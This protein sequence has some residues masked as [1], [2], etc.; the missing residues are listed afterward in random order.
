MGADGHFQAVR[1]SDWDET[2][3]DVKPGDCGLTTTEFLGLLI[4]YGY[5][6]TEG[7]GWREYGKQG[8]AVAVRSC[9]ERIT[10]IKENGTD[11]I[12]ER[13]SRFMNFR[14][15]KLADEEARL[16][17]LLADPNLAYSQRCNEAANWFEGHAQD[18]CVWT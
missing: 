18:I 13:K 5:W 14:P 3:A 12:Y 6:D 10:L 1:K 7:L 4:V 9:K 8:L 16:A 15:L 11:G 17:K 2:F